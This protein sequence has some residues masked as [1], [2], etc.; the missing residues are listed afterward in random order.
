MVTGATNGIGEIT[1]LELAKMGATVVIV[2][3]SKEKGER[4]QAEIKATTNNTNVDLML[5]DLSHMADVRKLAD[6]FN[7]KY[8]HLHVLV[9]NAGAFFT[10]YQQTEDGH[11]M[12][13]G[14]NHLSYFLL[15][16]LLLDKIKA[17]GTAQQNARIVNVASDAHQRSTYDRDSIQQTQANYSGL[18]AYGESKLYNIMFSAELARRLEAEGANV[19]SNSLH[20]G[21]VSTG[22]GHNNGFLTRLVLSLLQRFGKNAEEGAETQV[23]LASSPEAEAIT[24]KYFDNKQAKLPNAA[25]Q[26][27]ED[28]KH[29]W[30]Y[31]EQLLG[32]N[33]TA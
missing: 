33:A 2:A 21:L 15:T 19:V 29:L 27:V 13:F 10:G 30:T 6:E 24:G 25:A 16:N 22:F 5:A 4:V 8:D 9:N 1:A 3:R 23:Y 26:N 31:S 20:P 18:Q 11:E 17:S 32:M 12:T 28:Q 14:L 7:A